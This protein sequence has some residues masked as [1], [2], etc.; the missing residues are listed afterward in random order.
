M[1]LVSIW[2]EFGI[3]IIRINLVQT[4]TIFIERHKNW[5]VLLIKEAIKI[6]EIKPT[7]NSGLKASKELQ[8]F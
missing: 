3:L 5:N 1:N 4:N 8:L 6:K 7:L 2:S